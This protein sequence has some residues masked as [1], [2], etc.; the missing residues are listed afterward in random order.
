MNESDLKGLLQYT[1]SGILNRLPGVAQK[2]LEA[3][4]VLSIDWLLYAQSVNVDGG[5]SAGYNLLKCRWDPSYPEITGYTI[6]TL[7]N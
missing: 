3:H 5:L 1:L 2:R 7:I 4:L 6:P